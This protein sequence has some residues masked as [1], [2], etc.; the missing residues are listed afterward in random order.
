[1]PKGVLY[2]EQGS[3]EANSPG[4]ENGLEPAT[5]VPPILL[6]LLCNMPAKSA[7]YS[8]IFVNKLLYGYFYCIDFNCTGT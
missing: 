3:G 4:L 8:A 5:V 1:M 2:E 6:C 7:T